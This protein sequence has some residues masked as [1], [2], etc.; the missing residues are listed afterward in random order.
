MFRYPD[1][2]KPEHTERYAYE[3]C[4][5]SVASAAFDHAREC[6]V[7]PAASD[8]RRIA[9][10]VIDAQRDFCFPEGSLY[11]GGRS[12]KGAMD[13][14]RRLVEFIYRELPHITGVH[15]TGDT[16]EAFQIFSPAF[17]L[18]ESDRPLLPHDM[19]DSKCMVL[20]GGKSIG[21]ALPNPAVADMLGIP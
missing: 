2:Y 21:R 20:R 17:W 15:V 18:D 6:K 14:N 7:A 1:F 12:G 16:H 11:V 8:K 13:D 9:L 5:R 4:L 10:L 19:I 3:P